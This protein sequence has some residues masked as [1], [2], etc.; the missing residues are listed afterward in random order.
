M[1]FIY[2]VIVILW[3]RLVSGETVSWDLKKN[4][5]VII[6]TFQYRYSNA[7]KNDTLYVD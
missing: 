4:C 6:E 3:V 2:I 1:N 5:G 7:E